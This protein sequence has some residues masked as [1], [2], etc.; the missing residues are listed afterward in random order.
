VRG[1]YKMGKK[2]ET[3]RYS[4]ELH[5]DGKKIGLNPFVKAVFFNVVTGIVSTLKKTEDANEIVL[6]VERN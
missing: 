1:G 4:V 2:E 5:V 3:D 6:K